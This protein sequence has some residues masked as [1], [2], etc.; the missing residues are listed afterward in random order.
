MEQF[1]LR[2]RSPKSF[3][4][5]FLLALFLLAVLATPARAWDIWLVT[6]HNRILVIRDVETSPHQEYILTHDDVPDAHTRFGYFGFG[7]IGF[8]LTGKLYGISTTLE[9]KSHL[10]TID[11][12]TGHITQLQP[13]LPFEWGNALEFGLRT[14]IGYIGGG[15]ESYQPYRYLAGFYAFYDENPTTTTLW[16]DMRADYPQGGYTGGYTEANGYLYAIWGQGNWNSHQTYLLQITTDAA[17][18]FVSYTN[19]GDAESHGAPEG[20]WGLNS[21]GAHLYGLSGQTLYRIT[22]ENGVAT[23]HKVLDFSLLPGEHVNGSSS[24]IAD[25]SLNLTTS[26]SSPTPG[27]PFRLTVNIHNAGPYDANSTTAQV[28]LPAGL[29][30]VNSSTAT[31]T[32]AAA[33][34][35]WDVGTLPANQSATLTLTVKP[36]GSGSLTVQAQITHT[37]P[38]DPDSIASV[39]FAEDDWHDGQPDDDES[40]LTLHVG[41][42]PPTPTPSPP[43]QG[44]ILLPVTGFPPGHLTTLKPPDHAYATLT[45]TLE[46]PALALRAPIVGVP[47]GPQGW[48][49][50]WLGN[51]VGW[52][53]GTAFP[54]WAGN[55]VLTGHVWNADNTPGIFVNLKRLRFGDRILIHAGDLTYTYEVR[56]NR[57]LRPDDTSLALAHKDHNWLTLLTCEDYSPTSGTYRYRRMVRAVLVALR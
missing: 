36:E 5:G 9:Q 51:T 32:F 6:D 21:D 20:I 54:T 17:G 25:L 52:L 33:S 49:V 50:R 31:G 13:Q 29:T 14:D 48:D 12:N 11:L 40:T 46:I 42:P 47:Q 53:E 7:D 30:L 16:H 22:I 37:G 41:S 44:G 56:E 55:T 38:V 28:T 27:N 19:L 3:S 34:G 1:H 24:Q 4:L 43:P 23:Y 57:L 15:L 35:V 26:T 2:W 39:G 18:N 8:S 10:Y 45:L